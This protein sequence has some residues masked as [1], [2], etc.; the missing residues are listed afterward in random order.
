MIGGNITAL[1]QAKKGYTTNAIG[2]TS[3]SYETILELKGFLDMQSYNTHRTYLT[4]IEEATH[5]FICDFVEIEDT[6]SEDKI[7][8]VNNKSYEVLYI[9]NPMELNK[10]LEI[11]LKRIGG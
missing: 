8:I 4:K 11:Y 7:L 10:H 3:P 6:N 5:L 9:D 1:L 2:E